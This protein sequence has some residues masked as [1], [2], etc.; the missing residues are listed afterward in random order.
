MRRITELTK[1]EVQRIVFKHFGIDS[2]EL[3]MS[4]PEFVAI[5][6]D[7]GSE[8]MPEFFQVIVDNELLIL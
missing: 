3:S 8:K 7:G 4:F 6:K 1:D 2:D 5:A